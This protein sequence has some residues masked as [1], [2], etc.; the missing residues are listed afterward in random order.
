[1]INA[2]KN[3][4]VYTE[5]L[6]IQKIGIQFPH[7]LTKLRMHVVRNYFTQR[8]QY[9]LPQVHARVRNNKVCGIYHIVVPKDNINVNRP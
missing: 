4:V 5:V 2:K 1:M 8:L 6:I 3:G 9:K 7:C